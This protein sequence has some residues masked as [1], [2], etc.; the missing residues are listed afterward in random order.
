MGLWNAAKGYLEDR[1]RGRVFG[2][3]KVVEETGQI[4]RESE[5]GIYTKMVDA[6]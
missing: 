1:H 4:S 2:S 5:S 3:G 6:I